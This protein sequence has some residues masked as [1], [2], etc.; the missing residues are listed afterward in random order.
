MI[1]IKKLLLPTDFSEYSQFS[2]K[3]AAALAESFAAKVYVLHVHESYPQGALFEG[4]VYDADVAAKVEAGA[5]RD[6]DAVVAQL[7]TRQIQ[8]EPVFTSGQPYLQILRLAEE[9]EVDLIV[10]ATH[11]RRGISHLIFG[12]NAEKVVRLSPCPVLT[13]KHP[14]HESVG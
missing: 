5:R 6:L 7:T 1:A 9:L 14:D 8:A 13:V 4:M 11:G 2:L 3:Y 10:M 12:S